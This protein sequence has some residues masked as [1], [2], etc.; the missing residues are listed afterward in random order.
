VKKL[1][2]SL[3]KEEHE[4]FVAAAHEQKISL[5][6]WAKRKLRGTLPPAP[7]VMDEAFRRLDVA[8]HMRELSGKP[9]P[10]AVDPP[11]QRLVH[12]GKRL[13]T[14]H[15][16]V[17]HAHM[18][19]DDGGP[20]MVCTSPRQFARPCYWSSSGAVDCPHFTPRMAR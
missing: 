8:D 20:P 9:L 18:I 10:P 19:R 5:H 12:I 7:A 3:S 1:V 6:E 13:P 14:T 16:C 2:I 15:S 11:E 4:E 17:H